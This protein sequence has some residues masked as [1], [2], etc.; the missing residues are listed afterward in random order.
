MF[1]H[2]LA[3]TGLSHVRHQRQPRLA[4][5][6]VP[7][8]RLYVESSPAIGADGTIY[9]G[10]KSTIRLPCLLRESLRSQL[11]ISL[12]A[13]KK[14]AFRTGAYVALLAGDRGRRH[15]LLGLRRRSTLY[16]V[17]PDGTHKWKFTTGVNFDSSPAIGGDGTIYVGRGFGAHLYAVN[18]KGTE[19]VG[20]STGGGG[21]LIFFF[22]FFFFP[23]PP[24]LSLSL[25]LSFFFFIRRRSALTGT[26]YV[27]CAG[28][29]AIN[30]N[31]TPEVGVPD[32]AR[33]MLFTCD[34]H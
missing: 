28:L 31:G 25:S 32:E 26:I 29:C 22:F 14:W 30:S 11:T 5:V 16:A 9:F 4:E 24:F 13:R 10:V 8:R 1:H 19:K 23:P 20:K 2:D 17:N 12:T 18:P 21:F 27:N 3:H 6:E 33:R 15:D 34:R 7:N